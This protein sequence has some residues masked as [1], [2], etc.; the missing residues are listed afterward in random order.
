LPFQ[1]SPVPKDGC[2]Y[3]LTLL[4]FAVSCFNPHPS[5]RTGAT[6]VREQPRQH[7]ARFNPHP[8]RRTGATYEH[9]SLACYYPQT[10]S[11]LTR[12]EGRVQPIPLPCWQGD[13]YCFNPHPSRRT[14]ATSWSGATST[15][16]TVSIL[17]RPEGRVQPTSGS[18]AQI[19][20]LVSILTRPEGRV[21]HSKVKPVQHL[22]K[23]QSSPVPKDGCNQ[24]SAAHC[25]A[26]EGFNPHPSRRTGAT[27]A[28]Y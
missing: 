26:Q 27:P 19:I 22:A 11:I 20:M 2:N 16:T 18:F 10:V 25:T 12:P 28:C 4:D 13:F 6:G 14:G 1:S 9:A 5:R 8:S 24:G 23:F 15:F 21:Q 3:L 17:T 7:R